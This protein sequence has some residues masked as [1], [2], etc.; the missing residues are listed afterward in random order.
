MADLEETIF[1]QNIPG[2]WSKH[3]DNDNNNNNNNDDDNDNNNDEDNDND[4]IDIDHDQE[5]LEY[6]RDLTLN[7]EVPETVKQTILAER[8]SKGKSNT[9]VKGV[10]EDY[11]MAMKL[12]EAQRLADENF[13]NNVISRMVNGYIIKSDDL[14]Y[15]QHIEQ[16]INNNDD[17]DDELLE[18][19]TFLQ[20][21]R[22]K[23]LQELK[24]KNT[25][26]IFGNVIDAD[27]DTFINEID[28]VD[29]NIFVIVHLY[30]PDVHTCLR[31]N[32]ILEELC[33][34]M[35]H[36][37]FIRM[38]TSIDKVALPLINVYKAGEVVTVIAAIAAELATNYFTKE[39][40]QWLIESN[41]G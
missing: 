16:Q 7:S 11:K 17:S 10:I 22:T 24:T 2:R 30:D 33:E 26:P 19:D 15:Q 21:F 12:E 23:R 3:T 31:L 14:D 25:L 20:E 32:K 40:V 9:G 4:N 37:K 18:D 27:V 35:I 5:M 34:T 1:K 36:I 29:H 8:Y 39:D 41:L 28:N 6:A 13:R 38:Q